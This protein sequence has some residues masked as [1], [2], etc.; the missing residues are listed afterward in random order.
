[1]DAMEALS[2]FEKGLERA[3]AASGNT[4]PMP[5]GA[6]PAR[7]SQEI[8]LAAVV[9]LMKDTG[10]QRFLPLPLLMMESLA[11]LDRGLIPNLLRPAN[12]REQRILIDDART[13]VRAVRA[14][15]MLMARNH[16][17][18]LSQDA[19]ARLVY[20]TMAWSG[21]A[22]SPNAIIEWR[23]N[24]QRG[25]AAPDIMR[26]YSTPFPPE[27]GKTAVDKADWLLTTLTKGL[28][29]KWG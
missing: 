2:R 4:G 10:L 3:Q 29:I 8:W 13:V 9:D 19:A 18:R 11:N 1:M 17:H 16:P 27:A 15:D 23:K 20:E 26:I 5:K 12:R 24:V 28:V 14:I 22:K 25:R 7:W 6:T 21:L